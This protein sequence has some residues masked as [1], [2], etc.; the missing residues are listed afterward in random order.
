M[1]VYADGRLTSSG[2]MHIDSTKGLVNEDGTSVINP[3]D[4]T[5]CEIFFKDEQN[6]IDW[7]RST[8]MVAKENI[9]MP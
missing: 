8:I 4:I 3:E 1:N 5:N 9:V 6:F 2:K 7:T